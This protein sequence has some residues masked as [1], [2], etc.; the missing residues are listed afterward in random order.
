MEVRYL[1]MAAKI[2]LSWLLAVGSWQMF[3]PDPGFTSYSGDI[4]SISSDAVQFL[5]DAT[6]SNPYG[7]IESDQQIFDAVF[8]LIDAAENY[9]LLD[10]FLLNDFAN[11]SQTIH[12]DLYGELTVRLLHKKLY[13]PHIRIDLITDPINTVYS[14]YFNVQFE[15]MRKAGIQV[16]VTDLTKL[17]DSNPLYSTV[18][19]T[20]LQW[21]GNSDKGGLFPHPFSD[22]KPNV[23]LRSYLDLV[24][25]KANHRKLILADSADGYAAIVMSANPHNGSSAHSNVALKMSG[26]I[27][28][29]ILLSESRLASACGYSLQQDSLVF[30][31]A[32]VDSLRN[33]LQIQFLTEEKIKEDLLLSIQACAESDSISLAMFYLS[34]RDVVNALL[35]ASERG[36]YIRLILD[37]NRDAFGYEKN[38]IPNRQVAWE[39]I[40][41][42]QEKIQMRW[43]E[44]HGEQ[45]HTKMTLL[46][47][48]DGTSR[49]YLG[50]A[51]L[52]RRNLGN[53]NLESDVEVSGLN[54]HAVFKSAADYY[55]SLWMNEN[56]KTYTVP[57]EKYLEKSRFKY[58]VY[59]V[60]EFTGLCTY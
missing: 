29:D 8:A 58:F 50:S 39:L 3:K 7:K 22:T 40:N 25:F 27:C 10:M 48:K 32:K 44:T 5:Q 20:G 16:I 9:I 38:G 42:S 56:G 19:R 23:T 21:F 4:H 49:L 46:N 35:D 24:N 52:T 13:S 36:A 17:R 59:R 33:P 54:S 15:E 47:F 34:S 31:I 51:N 30:S 57:A 55:N 41:K 6:Y 12:R 28:G 53:Y 1:K 43:Y 26:Y 45:F 60:Q 14:G 18:W 2:L 37:A 11:S